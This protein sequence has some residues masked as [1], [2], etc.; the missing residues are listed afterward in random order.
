MNTWLNHLPS[1]NFQVI[2]CQLGWKDLSSLHQVC[3][4]AM[5]PVM[6]HI[7]SQSK[8]PLRL[9]EKVSFQAV[10]GVALRLAAQSLFSRASFTEFQLREILSTSVYDYLGSL[11]HLELTS[12]SITEKQLGVLLNQCSNLESLAIQGL[13]ISA[14]R[15]KNLKNL[16]KV[17]ITDCNKLRVIDFRGCPNLED[18]KIADEIHLRTLELSKNKE[19]NIRGRFN[20][21]E[22]SLPRSFEESK[23]MMQCM[24]VSFSNL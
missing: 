12:S 16:N 18:L 11:K 19:L 1:D 20:I 22:F 21:R 3:S 9:D 5:S 10:L 2:G 14:L 7:V 15:P 8:T 23:L 24:S 6:S 17:V 13:A 4:D